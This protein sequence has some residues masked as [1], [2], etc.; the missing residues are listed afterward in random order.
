MVQDSA[1]EELSLGIHGIQVYCQR[2]G[3]GESLLVLH[4]E[5]GASQ[6]RPFYAQLARRF[7][8]RVPDHPGFGRSGE[9]AWLERVQDLV[10]HYLD[11]LDM[12]GLE[13]VHLVGESF[14]GWLATALAVGSPER[15]R[16]LALIAPAGLQRPDVE[17]PD[18]FVMSPEQRAQAMFH[19]ERLVAEIGAQR[20]TREQLERQLHDRAMLA[21]LAWNPYLHDPQLPHWLHR[22]RVPTLL[23]WG[24]EDR[25]LPLA[26]AET[27]QQHLPRARLA[28]VDRAGHLPQVEQA[29]A[30]ARL[31]TEFLEE[32]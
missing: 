14:G 29:E 28:V 21:R 23:V 13:R 18:L 1:P 24:R 12:L 10:Y 3:Q 19:D 26:L 20:P 27:W 4:D 15:V 7:D 16:K 11:L 6:W 17:V 25:F 30:T 32:A 9:P 2:Q 31:V 5:D 22:A 8:V